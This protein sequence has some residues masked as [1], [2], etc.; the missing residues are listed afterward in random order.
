M[1]LTLKTPS[2]LHLGLLDLNGSLNR[3][4]G[5]IGVTIQKPGVVLEISEAE[6][7]LIQGDPTGRV[8]VLVKRFLHHYN[9]KE[10]VKVHLK[11]RIPEHVGLGSGTQ[12]SLAVAFGLAKFFQKDIPIQELARVMLRGYRSGIGIA[13]FTQGGFLVD[14][15]HPLTPSLPQ[16]DVSPPPILFRHPFP[17]NWIFLVVIPQ[18]KKGLS[19]E[20]EQQ[21]FERLLPVSS[22]Q[23]GEV[24]RI[25]VM[26]MLPA[27]IEENLK[28]FGEALTQIQKLVGGYF[29]TIQGGLFADKICE[30]LIEYML[31]CGAAGAGQSSWGPAVYGLVEGNQQAQ[32]LSCKVEE[33]LRGKVKATLF[34]THGQNTG[35]K[36]I[37]TREP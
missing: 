25:L 17:E 22:D 27:L 23:V 4:F 28:V 24:C 7:L 15:G 34:L 10:P 31:S 13:A 35:A 2:R 29:E 5:S 16:R 30:Q 18:V 6:E 36:V 21:A 19:G 37:E 32:E 9:L 33:F 3:I 8:E 14:G 12:L 26:Q 11:E 20:K 1:N